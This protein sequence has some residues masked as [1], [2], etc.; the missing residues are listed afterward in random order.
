VCSSDLAAPLALPLRLASARDTRGVTHALVATGNQLWTAEVDPSSPTPTPGLLQQRLAVVNPITS[1]AMGTAADAGVLAEG[2]FVA[3][4]SVHR[5]WSDAPSRWRA[6]EVT[7]SAGAV[8][9][10]V[11]FLNGRARAGM[12][13]GTVVS[14]PSRVRIVEPLAEVVEDY[15]QTCDQQLALTTSGLFAVTKAPQAVVGTWARVPL[16][17]G[18]APEGL[19]S[20]RLFTLGGDV[21]VFSRAGAAARVPVSRCP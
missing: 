5:L 2:Y 12:L 6:A 19:D 3:G 16:P 11:W 8:P 1:V 17:P 9:S 21:F 18:F 4:A 20:G 10:E 13:D 14:L 15:A 7:L